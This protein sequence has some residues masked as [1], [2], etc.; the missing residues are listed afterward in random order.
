MG[1][2]QSK[3]TRF[4]HWLT[5]ILLAVLFLVIHVAAPW[6][7]SLLSTRYGWVDGRPGA[8]NL[9]ALL[10]VAAGMAVTFWLIAQHYLAS[11]DTFL[12]MQPGQKLL[13]PGLYA[14]S[15]NPMYLSELAF[16]FGWAL[17]YGSITVLG[18]FLLWFVM[19]NFE[20]VPYEERDLERRFGEAYRQY[21]QM[22]P[23]WLRLRR[24]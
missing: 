3:G 2:E 23:R 6:G 16:W 1:K 13:T 4:P 12:E 17:F 19:F 14:F 20:I 18:G 15:R 8:W 10:L 7:L 24:R 21:K 11:A 22:V 5:P 9:L